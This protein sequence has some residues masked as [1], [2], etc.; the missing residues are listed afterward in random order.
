MN[1]TE[2]LKSIVAGHD[3]LQ[4]KWL[5]ERQAVMHIVDL[6]HWLTQEFHVSV[7]FV[8]WFLWTSALTDDIPA[9]IVLVENIWEELGEGKPQ[10]SHVEILR[11]FLSDLGVA[12]NAIPLFSATAE[13]LHLM[14]EITSS[15]FYEAIGALGPANEYLLKLEYSLM[16]DSYKKLAQTMDLPQARFF[17]INLEA[18]ESHSAKMFR[19]IEKV[20]I[21]SEKQEKVING[22][23]RALNARKLFYRGLEQID[24]SKSSS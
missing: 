13:Y 19:L 10:D 24:Y 12:D 16:Y 1:L 6:K 5:L 17:E 20:A 21:D 8:K 14:R 9:R 4:S 3:V 18:D 11:K 7:A 15:D 22:T 23:I 2:H